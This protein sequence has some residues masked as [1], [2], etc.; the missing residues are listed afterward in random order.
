MRYQT[1]AVDH[2]L[3]GPDISGRLAKQLHAYSVQVI[4]SL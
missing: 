4:L 3:G 2:I 1:Q